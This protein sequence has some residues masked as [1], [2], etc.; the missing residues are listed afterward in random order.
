MDKREY[1]FEVVGLAFSLLPCSPDISRCMLGFMP[2]GLW[3]R[4][5]EHSFNFREMGVRTKAFP[6]RHHQEAPRSLKIRQTP[7]VEK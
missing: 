7:R 1:V 4:W 5:A 6:L 2:H 3:G